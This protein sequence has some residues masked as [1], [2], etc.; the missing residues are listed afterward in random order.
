MRGVVIAGTGSGVG[1]T[2]VATGLMRKL[3]K[4]MKVQGFKV[5]PDF[6]D[7]MYHTSATGRCS[8]NLDSF[9]MSKDV[10]KNI[11]AYGSEG[12]DISVVEGVRGLYEGSSGKDDSGSTAEIAKL[13]GFPVVLVVDAGS[14][15]RS[16]AAIINGFRA[17]DKDIDLAGVILNN[18]SGTQ[19]ENKLKDAMSGSDIR[20]LGM[21]RRDAEYMT[22]KRHLG[23]STEGSSDKMILDGMESMADGIDMDQLMERC[24]GPDTEVVDCPYVKRDSGLTAAVPLD[25]AFCFYYRENIECMMA[26]GIRIEHFSP[27]NGDRLPDADI[28][29]LGGGYPELHLERLSENTDF[30]QGLRT[31]CDDN[32]AIIGE[33]GGMLSLCSTIRSGGKVYG[34]AGIFDAEA[35]MIGRRHGPSYVTGRAN[36]RCRLFSGTVKGHSYHY[37]T[38]YTKPD[39][40]FGFDILR[41]GG[42]FGNRDGMIR[43][44]AFGTYMYQHAL[45]VNDWMG[46]VVNICE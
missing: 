19:H 5:G 42:P 25:D 37:S 18:V 17:Y 13:L 43:R 9:M 22:P 11:A 40:K 24:Y 16:A 20:V 14:L 8:R 41:G 1:K 33:C 15:T 6:I 21:I 29:Y 36:D 31:A 12:A 30:F 38:V 46:A 45:S 35:D 28:Y 44:N 7:P 23:L 10:V 27:L 26:S 4:R 32:K 34:A 39:C 3:S 2:S